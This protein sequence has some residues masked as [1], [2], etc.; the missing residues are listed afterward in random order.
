MLGPRL[1]LFH[2]QDEAPGAAFWHPRGLLLYGLI[3]QYIRTQ[4]RRAGFQEVRTPQL[5]SRPLWERSGHWQKFGANMF[6]FADGDRTFALKPM[7][8]PCHVQLFR[9]QTRSYR[10]LPLRFAEFGACHRYEP[11]GAL[12]GLMRG[13]AFTQDDAHVFCLP[14]HVA[15]EVKAFCD[16][17]QRVY[18]RFGFR[19]FIVGFSTRPDSREGSDRVW[20]EAEA[21]LEA[22][23]VAAGLSFRQQRGAGAFYG[24]KLEFIL[25]DQQ[26]REWQCGTIQLDMVLPEKLDAEV[27]D[28]SGRGVRPLMLHHAVLGSLERFIAI[29]LEEHRGQ[30][31][32]WIA[33]EQII[34][35]PVGAE[36]RTYAARVAQALVEAGLRCRVDDSNETLSRRILSAHDL[37]IPVFATVGPREASAG[38]VTLRERS[39]S[40]RVLDIREAVE[41]LQRL[42]AATTD[43]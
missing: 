7:S 30:L 20:D 8:C 33:P 16:L 4:M 37:G 25:Q 41:S 13:R 9:Q 34:V 1:D 11:S 31:P 6:V 29:V 27:V 36:Q 22:A 26:H 28:S 19:Q 38:K 10:D 12:H 24:P 42:A 18:R 40:C 14:E 15:S 43:C 17:L 23:A 21:M 32:F 39:G 2:L 5:L 35:A 3:E